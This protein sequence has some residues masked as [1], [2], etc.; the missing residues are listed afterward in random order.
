[1]LSHKIFLATGLMVGG[2]VVF[3]ACGSSSSDNGTTAGSGG[4]T[5]A[6]GGAG[7]S[8]VGTGGTAGTGGRGAGGFQND[9]GRVACGTANMGTGCNPNGN[10]RVCDLPNNRCVQCLSSADCAA[11]PNQMN[12]PFCDTVGM[13]M[14]GLPNDT[15][16]E[17]LN[18]TQCGAG[19]SCVNNNCVVSCT[20]DAQCAAA[21]PMTPI[22]NTA[23]TPGRCVQCVTDAHC[24][25]VTDMN[26]VARPHCRL[27]MTN[28]PNTC[29][30]CNTAADCQ[31]GQVCSQQGNC[32]NP[33]DA[34]G[35]A[36]GAGGAPPSDASAG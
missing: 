3:T 16:E 14:A 13:T 23:V 10:T 12:N 9:A 30:A 31:P 27:P 17:C 24:A 6:T 25:G 29:R 2:F 19:M 28:N 35:G 4:T 5:V 32:N 1:M 11:N 22:C 34:G 20:T 18:D 8:T 33:P 21:L 36:G 26:G 7:G 15:C